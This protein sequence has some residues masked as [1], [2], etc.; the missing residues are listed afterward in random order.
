MKMENLKYPFI[1]LANKIF[2]LGDFSSK[3][4]SLQHN[5]SFSKYISQNGEN[6]LLKKIK[7][8]HTWIKN[9]HKSNKKLM[10]NLDFKWFMCNIFIN[11]SPI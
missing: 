5:I 10:F 8:L 3:T 11:P 2:I 6:S 9:C 4:W 1:L 7:Q